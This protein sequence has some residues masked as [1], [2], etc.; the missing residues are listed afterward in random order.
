M[1]I[2]IARPPADAQDTA[3]HD[4]LDLRPLG[5]AD[6]IAPAF[7]TALDVICVVAVIVIFAFGVGMYMPEVLALLKGIVQ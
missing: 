7:P 3:Y 6:D 4:P 2:R 5:Q 1:S